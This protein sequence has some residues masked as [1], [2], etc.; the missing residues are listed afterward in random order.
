M[1]LP[2]TFAQTDQSAIFDLIESHSFGLLVSGAGEELVASHLPLLLA[3]DVPLQGR[4]IGHMAR[5]NPQWRS[6]DGRQ[7]LCVFSGPHAYIS[8]SWYEAA[9]VV[10]TWNYLAVHAYGTCRIIDD[11]AAAARIVGDYVSTYERSQAAPWQLDASTPYFERMLQAIVAFEI[12]ITR[13]EGKW[14]LGQNHAAERREKT[15]ARLDESENAEARE[16]GRLMRETL[17]AE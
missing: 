9:E 11:P 7:V 4:L 14:K 2:A 17:G 15:A 12:D 8:P 13:L 6:L 10:P 5:A 1:Y 3:R 16:I